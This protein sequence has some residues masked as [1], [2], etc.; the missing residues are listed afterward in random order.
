MMMTLECFY[1]GSSEN[2]FLK[3]RRN[4]K[5]LKFNLKNASKIEMNENELSQSL[6]SFNDFDKS[7][8]KDNEPLPF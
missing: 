1:F 6:R 2:S 4:I 5:L 7:E 3:K 8:E